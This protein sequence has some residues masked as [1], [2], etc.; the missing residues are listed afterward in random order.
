MT[1]PSAEGPS[2]ARTARLSRTERQWLVALAMTAALV[3]LF[4]LLGALERHSSANADRATRF[5]W[6][7]SETP[8]RFLAVAHTIVATSFLVTSKKVRRRGTALGLLGCAAIGVLACL[9]FRALG[10]MGNAIAGF[11]FYA[12]FIAHE[13]RDEGYLTARNGDQ[14]PAAPDGSPAAARWLDWTPSLLVVLLLIGVGA[15]GVA[16]GGAAR[17]LLRP[18]ASIDPAVRIGGSLVVLLLS[19]LAGYLVLARA[20][21]IEGTT[22]LGHLSRRRPR[23][24]VTAG[25]L[26]VLLA[27]AVWTGRV[28]LIVAVHVVWWAVFAYDGL[29]RA[30]RPAVRPVPF[31]W[32]WARTTPM[33]F[34]AFHGAVMLAVVGVGAAHALLAQNDPSWRFAAILA[35]RDAFPYWTLMHVSLSWLPRT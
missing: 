26:L 9:G 20:A 14:G 8:T 4:A 6:N 2:F 16:S 13:L 18:F 32:A 30:P 1:S 15:A 24:F 12:Y 11:L 5:V 7:S 21:R 34:V 3:A 10:G 23:V 17:K 35:G 28:Y 29:R 33:G 19:I 22:I 25:L 27:G 31:T